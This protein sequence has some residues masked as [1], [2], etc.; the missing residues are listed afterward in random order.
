[1]VIAPPNGHVVG[2]SP[3]MTNGPRKEAWRRRLLALTAAIAQRLIE[4][5][6]HAD[7]LSEC[8]GATVRRPERS[9]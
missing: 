3:G 8:A 9:T 4:Q 2:T 7:K 1:M 5:G 6:R